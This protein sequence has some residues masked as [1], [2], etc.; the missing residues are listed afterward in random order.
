[1]MQ[2]SLPSTWVGHESVFR[3][4]SPPAHAVSGLFTFMMIVS[5]IVYLIVIAVALYSLYHS[6]QR[7]TPEPGDRDPGVRRAVTSA[8]VLTVV[9]LFGYLF[10]NFG[11]GRATAAPFY[12]TN[13]LH[14][15]VVGHQWWWEVQYN[16]TAPQRRLTTANEIHVPIN[17]PVLFSL[18]STDVIHS[19]WLPNL[20]GKRDLIPGHPNDA[21]FQADTAGVYR[22]QCAEFCGL[23]HGKMAIVVVAETPAQYQQWYDAQLQA[24]TPPADSYRAAGEQVFMAGPCAMCHAISGT[25]AGATF[26]P[27]LT[28]LASRM[29]LAAG[30]LPNTRANLAGWIVDP[31]SIKPGANMPANNLS[32]R[33]LRV[34]IAY[35]EG[36][37]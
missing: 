36:L 28:H 19:F 23:E 34:L 32:P 21:W 9:I 22:G 30:V 26:G 33:D 15:N 8:S 35:L 14:I 3:P 7:A 2:P 6:H 16:D 25:P 10:Y 1:M 4:S 24:A 5:G 37:K 18:T 31:Q 11:V 27:D 29:T 13:A 20:N 12:A 17:R